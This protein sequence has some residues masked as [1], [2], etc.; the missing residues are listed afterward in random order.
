MV[1]FPDD[2]QDGY[3]QV[4]RVKGQFVYYDNGCHTVTD[5]DLRMY[6]FRMD[7]FP[8]WLC[9]QLKLER[10]EAVVD[11]RIWKLGE[12]Q[13]TTI[14]LVRSLSC[15]FDDVADYL[16]K[17]LVLP[18]I[19]ISSQKPESKYQALPSG[20]QLLTLDTLLPDGSVTL[21]YNYFLSNVDPTQALLECEG[22]LW[23]EEAGILRVFGHEPWLLKG[24]P[25]RCLVISKL[26]N[27]GK[28]GRSPEILTQLLLEHVKSSNLSQFFGSDKR[29]SEFIGYKPGASGRC[30]LRYFVQS[31]EAKKASA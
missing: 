29:W 8:E 21:D 22:I 14:L 31:E 26:Y 18:C 12:V 4:H 28:Y 27:A 17:Q 7:W 11:N 25:E 19:V 20:C 24:S 5:D 1:D 13:G 16:F 6:R 9:G 15:S 23:D 2:R 3:R 10:F 30:W